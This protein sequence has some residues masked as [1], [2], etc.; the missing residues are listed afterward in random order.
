MWQ[1]HLFIPST[2]WSIELSLLDI[3]W[4]QMTETCSNGSGRQ[5]F[6]EPAGRAQ[7]GPWRSLGFWSLS[8]AENGSF[9]TV[10]G[11]INPQAHIPTPRELRPSCQS[12]EG[13]S[14]APLRLSSYLSL[15]HPFVAGREGSNN[16]PGSGYMVT[17]ETTS[18]AGWDLKENGRFC[19]F[20]GR[21]SVSRTR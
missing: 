11:T 18:L 5:K 19:S 13:L 20:L 2:A 1:H 4:L 16:W 9:C 14:L 3:F 10:G 15:N 6:R 12:R 8:P 17:S 7:G 21:R